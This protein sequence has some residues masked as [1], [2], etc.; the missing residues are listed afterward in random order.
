LNYFLLFLPEEKSFVNFSVKCD[1][2]TFLPT[3]N[4]SK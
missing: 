2:K 4:N 1:G 3:Q